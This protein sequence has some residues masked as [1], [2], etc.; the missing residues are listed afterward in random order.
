MSRNTPKRATRSRGPKQVLPDLPKGSYADVP[1][2]VPHRY[3]SG[4]AL[5]R[6]RL[7]DAQR[8][9]GWRAKQVA[10]RTS[11]AGSLPAGQPT[12][13]VPS[14]AVETVVAPEPV[15]APETVLEPTATVFAELTPETATTIEPGDGLLPVERMM[16]EIQRGRS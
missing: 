10:F 15:A 1:K 7:Y 9:R 11:A 2:N 13:V 4:E 3:L 14:P 16:I 8:Q 5:E 12:M 6:R